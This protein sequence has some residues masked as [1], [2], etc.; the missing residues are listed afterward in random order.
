MYEVV[1]DKQAQKQL[2]TIRAP[3]Y[4]R[5]VE[6]LADL[7]H[8]PRPHGYK[9]LKGRDGYRIRVG[10]YRII[11]TLRDSILAVY[12]ITIDNRKDVYR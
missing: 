3:F 5:I 12:I 1:I 2:G 11:Y 10:D 9:K 8:N 6:A 4:H 7:A